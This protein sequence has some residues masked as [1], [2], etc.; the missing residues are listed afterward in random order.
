MDRVTISERIGRDR[1]IL[2]AVAIVWLVAV[3]ALTVA[4]VQDAV[5]PGTLMRDPATTTDQPASLGLFSSLGVIAWNITWVV[6]AGSAYLLHR[7]GAAIR[8]VRFTALGA[9][10]TA[11][12]MLD[13]L[14]L[15]HESAGRQGVP[16]SLIFGLYGLAAL[17]WVWHFRA[18]LLATAA[19]V[20]AA[21]AVLFAVSFGIDIVLGGS[22]ATWRIVVEDGTK[23]MAILTLAVWAVAAGADLL[24]PRL[25]A[26][27]Q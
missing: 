8:L 5:D 11:V 1:R 14:F 6:L 16:Q 4:G 15:G 9:G 7:L 13:D 27:S 24:E 12:L 23:F 17:A 10:L 19:T 20:L 2:R 26:G 22:D 3:A 18:E 25:R 21:A